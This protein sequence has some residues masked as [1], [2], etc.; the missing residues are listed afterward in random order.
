MNCDLKHCKC[1][2]VNYTDGTPSREVENDDWEATGG[3]EMNKLYDKIIKKT[4][5][6][7]ILDI[8][9]QITNLLDVL[10]VC[11]AA[12]LTDNA[13]DAVLCSAANTLH[14][15]VS[16]KLKLIEEELASI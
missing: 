10:R 1:K 5:K 9:D 12:I 16:E 14:F 3:D 15:Q 6:A 13:T 11:T 2:P 7:S 4:P 8:R